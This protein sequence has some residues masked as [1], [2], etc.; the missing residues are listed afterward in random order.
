[1]HFKDIFLKN[2]LEKCPFFVMVKSKMKIGG[3]TD[4]KHSDKSREEGYSHN[5]F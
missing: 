2:I 5:Y 3:K 4:G 1:M